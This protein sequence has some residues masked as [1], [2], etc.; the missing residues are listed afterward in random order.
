M[1]DYRIE[2]WRKAKQNRENAEKWNDLPKGLKYNDS[3]TFEISSGHSLSPKLV[4]AGQ[5]Y[6]DGNNYWDSETGL[7]DAILE[8]IIADWDN[9]YP[10]V[11]ALLKAKERKA[12]KTCQSLIDETQELINKEDANEVDV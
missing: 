11:L 10:K 7:N 8:Y 5:Q 2:R 3:Q 9:I 4:R 6:H 1:D 12:L